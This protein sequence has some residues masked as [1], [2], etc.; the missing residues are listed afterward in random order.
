MIVVENAIGEII[1]RQPFMRKVF[2]A[3]FKQGLQHLEDMQWD[4]DRQT[5]RLVKYIGASEASFDIF[6]RAH[7]E[8]ICRLNDADHYAIV[9]AGM[10]RGT[11][12]HAMAHTI[13]TNYMY[14]LTFN[15]P[16]TPLSGPLKSKGALKPVALLA[17]AAAAAEGSPSAGTRVDAVPASL[18]PRTVGASAR[19]A[20]KAES[21]YP[22]NVRHF[23]ART[24][25]G[26][27]VD[28]VETGG[29]FWE[30]LQG[31]HPKVHWL[32]ENPAYR[33]Q[34]EDY[35]LQ[36]GNKVGEKNMSKRDLVHFVNN[37]IFKVT[38]TPLTPS[39]LSFLPP[40]P[41][42]PSPSL[43]RCASISRAMCVHFCCANAGW[44][45]WRPHLEARR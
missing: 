30:S 22:A 28:A 21:P 23:S 16:L 32:L 33:Q 17:A 35:V 11:Q 8:E 36:N 3:A 40:S 27:H 18:S 38:L 20:V 42:S 41:V 34:F 9:A 4:G 10:L 39:S 44:S 2:A 43:L 31:Q 1:N 14:V 45:T 25:Q 13:T 29:V 12:P 19:H 7:P 6:L 5:V 26:Y 24:V 15:P 37:V